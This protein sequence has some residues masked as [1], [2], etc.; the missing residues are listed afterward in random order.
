MT[1]NN[2]SLDIPFKALD[3]DGELHKGVLH[4]D[5]DYN[6]QKMTVNSQ[7]Q[8]SENHRYPDTRVVYDFNIWLGSLQERSASQN[9]GLYM[10]K[11]ETIAN[12]FMAEL[13][14][15]SYVPMPPNERIRDRM[16]IDD[17]EKAIVIGK[18]SEFIDKHSNFK[19]VINVHHVDKYGD[20]YVG[21]LNVN[22]IDMD[23]SVLDDKIKVDQNPNSVAFKVVK[24][25]SAE[26]VKEIRN[27]LEAYEEKFNKF[28]PRTFEECLR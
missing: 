24:N 9:P 5:F 11:V 18:L 14:N 15:S 22:G 20:E 7:V 4:V 19:P 8:S 6:R 28:K 25:H 10:A 21:V 12:S 17:K 13:A 2:F 27:E 3:S 26:I 23:L 1:N 16:I